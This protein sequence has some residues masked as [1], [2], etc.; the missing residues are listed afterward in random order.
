MK[1]L[2]ELVTNPVTGRLS[3]SDT[4]IVAAF[5]FSTFSLVWHTVIQEQLPEWLFIGYMTAWVM[6]SQASKWS[7]I[8]RDKEVPREPD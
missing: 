3:T 2:L 1:R 5:V 8:K 6:Q 4:I 7:S